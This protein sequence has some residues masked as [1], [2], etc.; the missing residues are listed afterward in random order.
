MYNLHE[1]LKKITC[2]APGQQKQPQDNGDRRSS[3]TAAIIIIYAANQPEDDNHSF[4]HKNCN[5]KSYKEPSD[6]GFIGAVAGKPYDKRLPIY[7][8]L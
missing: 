3:P 7:D 5:A 4:E 2:Y 6:P 1:R 8:K